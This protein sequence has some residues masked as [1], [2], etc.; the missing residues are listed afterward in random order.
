MEQLFEFMND[1]VSPFHAV[2]K[3]VKQL[4]KAGFSP[5][6]EMEPWELQ[7][8]RFYYVTRNV[9]S[10]IAFQM[11]QDKPK[12]YHLTASHSDSP[13]FRLKK[14]KMEGSYYARA[15]VEGYG[16]MI[17]SS[18]LDRPLGMAGRVVVRTTEGVRTELIAP[19]RDI[20][21]IP[22]LSIHM[23]RDMNKGYTYNPQVDLQPLYGGEEADLQALIARE[24]G[25]SKEDVLDLD[26]VLS[27]R[28]KALKFGAEEEYYMAPRIDDLACAYT[29]L[30]G[31]LAA[32]QK[33]QV[34]TNKT[35]KLKLWCM[36]DNEEVGSGTR[37]GALGAFLPDVLSRI[38]EIC[39]MTAEE[40]TMARNRSLLI[41]A[42]NAHATH[43]N[44]PAKTD[45]E[46][47]VILNKGVV[48]KYNAS[49]RYTTTGVTAAVFANLCE[50][51]GVPIQRFANRADA[52][53]GSTLGNLLSH[54]LSV[55]ML[56]IGLPQLAMHSAVETAGCKDVF[57]M[58]KAMQAFY[59][60]EI[61]QIQDGEWRMKNP[62]FF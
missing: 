7:P 42:D 51:I 29:T 39:D 2:K 44:L 14:E 53:G 43:P 36:F 34:D 9:S 60:S 16:G 15:E 54:Q 62:C 56:D 27:V 30:M 26:I 11:P 13:T 58:Q 4:E 61:C 40:S 46:F 45:S 57:F 28:Q 20:F 18:W 3:A 5:L 32:C 12:Y 6:S 22:N 1:A 21:V 47:P 24:A 25:C 23:N 19:D 37:Q 17:Y 52:P 31:F 49:Q 10:M 59:E 8:G 41:S 48:V 33:E 50:E 35:Q 55:P 38:E